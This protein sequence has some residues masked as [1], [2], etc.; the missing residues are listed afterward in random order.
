MKPPTLFLIIGVI[1]ALSLTLWQCTPTLAPGDRDAIND[2]AAKLA[3]CQSVGREAG[4]YEA[5]DE[6]VR[7]NGLRLDG[8]S[9]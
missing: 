7:V 6:C 5:Y 2:T 1:S 9:P 8:G 4:S 3:K